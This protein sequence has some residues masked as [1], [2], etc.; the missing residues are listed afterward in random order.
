MMAWLFEP[1]LIAYSWP[2]NSPPAS[3]ESAMLVVSI[4]PEAR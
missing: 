1:R 2:S 3:I 4:A